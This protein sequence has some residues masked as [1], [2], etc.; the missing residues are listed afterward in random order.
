MPTI[1]IYVKDDVY[2]KYKSLS[3]EEQKQKQKDYIETI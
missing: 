1:A 3:K 2:F